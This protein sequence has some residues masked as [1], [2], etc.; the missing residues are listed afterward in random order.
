MDQYALPVRNVHF[1]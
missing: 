1:L